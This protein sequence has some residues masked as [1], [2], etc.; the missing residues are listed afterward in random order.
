M[1]IMP[2]M[3]SFGELMVDLHDSTDAM[4]TTTL[5]VPT[6]SGMAMNCC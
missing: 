4:L 2:N 1:H 6:L 5:H 3:I